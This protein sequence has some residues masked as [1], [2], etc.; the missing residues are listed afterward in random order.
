MTCSRWI[1]TLWLVVLCVSARAADLVLNEY[2]AVAS[3]MGFLGGGGSDSRL[4][5]RDGNGGDWLELVV[6]TDH[7]DVR[8]WRVVISHRTGEPSNPGPGQQ[9]YS[10]TFSQDPVWEDLRA[11]TILTISEKISQNVDDYLPV[12]GKWWLNVRA[13]IDSGGRYITA[14]DFAVSNDKTQITIENALGENVFGPAGEGISPVSGVGRDEVFKLEAKPSATTSPASPDYAAGNSSSYGMPNVWTTPAGTNSQD[15]S[16]LRSVVPYFPLSQVVINEI[17]THSDPPEEDWIELYNPG[18]S[19]V[20]IGGWFLGDGPRNLMQYSIP[21]GTRIPAG[22]YVIVPESALPF[23]LDGERGEYVFLS[24]GD[25]LGGM[26]GERDYVKFGALENGVSFGRSPSGT[27]SF[28]RMEY[29]TPGAANSGAD[30]GPLVI[31]EVMY[32]A[33]GVPPAGLSAGELDFIELQ[34]LSPAALPLEVDYGPE[35]RFG[36]QIGD[37]VDYEFGGGASIAAESYLVVVS[38]APDLEP[39][40]LEAFRSHY[41]IPIEIPVYGPYAG[42]LNNYSDS[43]R[44]LRPD[45]PSAGLA[46]MVERDALTYFDMDPWPVSADGGGPSLERIYPGFAGRSVTYWGAS[47]LPGGTPGRLNSRTAEVP[48]PSFLPGISAG[49][50]LLGFLASVRRKKARRSPGE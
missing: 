46:P 16:T 19:E 41:S 34:N 11:G 50:V 7:L 3:T 20:D 42:K 29:P 43:L 33:G 13:S 1:F 10:L 9:I 17:N 27:G 24:E 35:G 2:N 48:E 39:L 5:V 28:F 37:G 45:S 21:T 25:G 15:F 31:G 26:S 23:A 14:S 40:K 49:M 22:G 32:H 18:D 8:G 30:V 12:V 4:G 36:W 47:E 44:L 6:V 38:F